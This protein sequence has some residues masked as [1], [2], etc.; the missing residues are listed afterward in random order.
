M[1]SSTPCSPMTSG[2]ASP[3]MALPDRSIAAAI[4][5]TRRELLGQ[6]TNPGLE[7]RMLAGSALGLDAS[8]LIAYGENI[9]D[10]ARR[11]HLAQM[12]SRRKR[13]EPIAYIVG[14][15]DFCGLRLSVTPDVLIPRPETEELVAL[16]VREAGTRPREILDLGT[17]SGAIACALANVLLEAHVTATDVSASALRVATENAA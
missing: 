8:A 10:D 9:I 13:G 7:A 5:S 14:F 2:N 6:A 4:E 11:R 17:G 16:I 15:K 3:A 1:T 12:T